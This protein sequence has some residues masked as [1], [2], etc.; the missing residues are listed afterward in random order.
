MKATLTECSKPKDQGQSVPQTID[1]ILTAQYMEIKKQRK[2]KKVKY[3]KEQ[4]QKEAYFKLKHAG[5]R[6][7]Y[8]VQEFLINLEI[9]FIKPTVRMYNGYCI[10]NSA[11]LE[12]SWC[13]NTMGKCVNY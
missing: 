11:Q 12:H 10:N 5:E 13:S 9:G 7:Y 3:E 2:E 6:E 4:E 8:K 1:R